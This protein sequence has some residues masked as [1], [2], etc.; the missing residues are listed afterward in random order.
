[1]SSVTG[2]QPTAA[3]PLQLVLT[4]L[5]RADFLVLLKNRRAVLVQHPAAGLS[6][7]QHELE[8]GYAALRGPVVRDRVGDRLRARVDLDHGLR[9]HGGAR[10]GEGRVPAPTCDPCSHVD[11]HDQSPGA[12]NRVAN[13]IIALVVV[14]VGT[15]LH[16][17]SPSPGEYALVLL[18][19]ILA[20]GVF[21][22]IGQALSVW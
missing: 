19:S 2:A 17:L 4:S 13:L 1:M 16:H 11:D 22:S 3:P 5:F 14:I 20:G 12:C 9:D 7:R 18:V 15:R 10:P 21:L 6:A 8:H